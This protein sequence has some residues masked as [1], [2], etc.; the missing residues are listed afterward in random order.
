MGFPLPVARIEDLLQ[1]KIWAAHDRTRR[2][3]KQL[4]DLSDIAR[5]LEVEP[6]LRNQVPAEILSKIPQQL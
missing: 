6:Q 3:S 5:I 2:P 1:G 4:K